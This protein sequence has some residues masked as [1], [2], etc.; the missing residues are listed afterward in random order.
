[1][2]WMESAGD[3]DPNRARIAVGPDYGWRDIKRAATDN[4]AGCTL[5]EGYV[6][7]LPTVWVEEAAPENAS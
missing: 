6:G 1:M 7:G 2:A 5:I 4:I 3:V